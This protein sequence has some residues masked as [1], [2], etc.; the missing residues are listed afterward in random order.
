MQ[1][2][3]ALRLGQQ[4]G[5]A[6][7]HAEYNMMG[8]I[9]VNPNRPQN[10]I[11]SPIIGRKPMTQ[12]LVISATNPHQVNTRDG[13]LYASFINAAHAEAFVD[14]VRAAEEAVLDEEYEDL[15][16]AVDTFLSALK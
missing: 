4:Y 2:D 7:E 11:G 16:E 14:F 10:V 6:P 13:R 9:Y 3:E 5:P 15:D 12:A 8:G 1:D